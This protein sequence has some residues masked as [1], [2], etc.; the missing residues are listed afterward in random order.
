MISATKKQGI[1]QEPP[2]P[3]IEEIERLLPYKSMISRFAPKPSSKADKTKRP[4]IKRQHNYF[5]PLKNMS[6]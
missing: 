2:I 4:K 3:P 1:N 5:N 6:H